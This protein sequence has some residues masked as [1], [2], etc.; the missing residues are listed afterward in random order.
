MTAYSLIG[1]VTGSGTGYTVNY[2]MG[3]L[4]V[5]YPLRIVSVQ[6]VLI[7]GI[8]GEGFAGAEIGGATSASLSGGSAI[9][10]VPTIQ[11]APPS[12]ASARG[13]SPG[14]TISGTTTALTAIN[15]NAGNAPASFE[16]PTD[17]ILSPGSALWASANIN[18][19]DITGS[20]QIATSTG[21]ITFYFEEL[22]LIWNY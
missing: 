14:I 5:T 12:T 19:S 22:R 10:P 17:Y 2:G 11:G 9:T 6:L 18:E 4:A 3:L 8:I 20:G 15:A 1:S 13:G 7:G 16:F 21:L